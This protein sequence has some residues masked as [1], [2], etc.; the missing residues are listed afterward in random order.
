MTVPAVVP[1]PVILEKAVSVA[2]PFNLKVPELAI[3][4]EVTRLKA[5]P[6]RSYVD[7]E[8]IV[9]DDNLIADP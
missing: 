2:V 9:N 5:N 6:A 1:N 7:P 8:A 4:P 3:V